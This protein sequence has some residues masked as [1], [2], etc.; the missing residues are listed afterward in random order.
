[1]PQMCYVASVLLFWY[2]I[3][4]SLVLYDAMSMI[5]TFHSKWI[6]QMYNEKC[7][8]PFFF[9]NF[10]LVCVQCLLT[11]KSLQIALTLSCYNVFGSATFADAS[12][13]LDPLFSIAERRSGH[14][15]CSVIIL[16]PWSIGFTVKVR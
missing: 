12:H 6:V 10:L 8:I 16:N 2:Q 1:M 14:H 3:K 7:G 13:F 9:C 15:L 4:S 11:S 5:N